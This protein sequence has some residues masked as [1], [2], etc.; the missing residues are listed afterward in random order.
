MAKTDG[1]EPLTGERLVKEVCRLVRAARKHWDAHENLACRR[2]RD[3][4]LELYATLTK[5]QKAEIPRVLLIWLRYRSEK[6]FGESRTPPDRTGA[7]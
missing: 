4:A 6:Y 2:E 7:S 1:D 5:G 3:R